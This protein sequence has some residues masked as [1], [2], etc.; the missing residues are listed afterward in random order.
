MPQRQPKR[1][2][3]WLGEELDSPL[4]AKVSIDRR[5]VRY[6]NVRPWS[7]PGHR[8]RRRRHSGHRAPD[9]GAAL[10]RPG[11]YGRS[12]RSTNIASGSIGGGRLLTPLLSRQALI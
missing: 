6:D 12:G 5:W 7:S 2:R 8:R 11:V 3:L 4:E 9:F 10:L 1:G